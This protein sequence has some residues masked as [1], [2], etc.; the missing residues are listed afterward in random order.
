VKSI[1][2]TGDVVHHD[3]VENYN[4]L[5][6]WAGYESP[7]KL[8]LQPR[9]CDKY[10]MFHFKGLKHQKYILVEMSLLGISVGKTMAVL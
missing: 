1:G 5:R 3:W 4:A 7:G 2:H 10:K 6:R 8:H 9:V